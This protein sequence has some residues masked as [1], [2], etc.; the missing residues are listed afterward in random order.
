MNTTYLDMIRGEGA[1]Y[2]PVWFMRQAGRSQPVYRKI[3]EKYSLFEITRQPEL[4]A[5]VTALP[6]EDYGVDA[7]ILYKDIMT[8]LPSMGIPVELRAGVGPIIANPIRTKADVD[9]LQDFTAETVPVYVLQT[10]RLL[11]DDILKVPL[12]GFAGAPFTL[13]SYLIEGG[14]S[15][16]YMKTRGMMLGAPQVWAALMDKL[17]AMTAVYLKAQAEAGAQALQLFDSWVGAVSREQY[18]TSIYPYVQRILTEVK[19]AYPAV[20]VTMHGVGCVH[21]LPL[22]KELPL[23]VI[24]LDWR[25]S[26][27]E[28]H[29]L[30][31]RQTLQGNL[32]PAWLYADWS[33]IKTELDRILEEG[34]AHGRHIFNL[35]HGVFPEANPD[36][37][38]QIAA[39]IHEISAR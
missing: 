16:T 37:L 27:S 24:G 26:I 33:A 29:N 22:W 19:S 35:G 21:L 9:N 1:A 6:V 11:V 17:T 28:A 2:T 32:D 15:K 25:C 36:I 10:I 8:P 23:D 30:G 18:M 13:A 4:A 12:I 7:A 20:P 3:K 34:R 5:R 14:P 31:I 39:Y 38:K